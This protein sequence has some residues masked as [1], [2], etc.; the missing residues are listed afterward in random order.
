[1]GD[2]WAYDRRTA[3]VASP[4][5]LPQVATHAPPPCGCRLKW[6]DGIKYIIAGQEWSSNDIEHGV[7]RGNAASPAALL[8]L[9]GRPQWAPRQFPHGD[10]RTALVGLA[11]AALF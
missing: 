1:M 7:L 6:Y 4:Q 9:L 2:E 11:G 8:S 10:P 5:L 3:A